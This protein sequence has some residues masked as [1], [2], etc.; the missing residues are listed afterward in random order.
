MRFRYLDDLD[1]RVEPLPRGCEHDRK[2]LVGAEVRDLLGRI[3]GVG[4]EESRRADEDER[5][6]GEVDVLLVFDGVAGNGL[7]AELR[8]LD[9]QL[10]GR[11]ALVSAPDDRPVA[12]R[13]RVT[14]RR[15]SNAL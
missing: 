4:S 6:C 10:L 13:K 14:T 9:P 12:A 8:Q 5:L 15:S 11:D 7:V 2:R 3:V 1:R